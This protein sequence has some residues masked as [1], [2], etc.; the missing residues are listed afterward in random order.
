MNKWKIA[1]LTLSTA[2]LLLIIILAVQIFRP[3]DS[4]V[5]PVNPED[6]ES[7]AEFTVSA[8]RDDLTGVANR[9]IREEGL[10]GPIDYS[11]QFDDL[12]TLNGSIPVFTSEIDFQMT[13]EAQA[14]EDGNLL[15]TQDRL[16]LGAVDLPVSY[17]LK[18]I[19]DSYELPEWVIIQ[20][21]EQQILVRVTDIEVPG[22][23]SVKANRFDLPEDDLSFS[24][25]VPK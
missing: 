11:V 21:D 7:Q 16:L 1:F 17:I 22:G 24:I 5:S 20:P 2:L 13:F 4:S 8:S 3:I 25:Y 23:L 10:D 9:Y 14:L 18:F 12:V 15:L 19:R 6:L